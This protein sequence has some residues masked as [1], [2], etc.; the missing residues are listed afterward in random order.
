MGTPTAKSFIDGRAATDKMIYKRALT[1]LYGLSAD[2]MSI[3]W[4]TIQ[5]TADGVMPDGTIAQNNDDIRLIKGDPLRT[6][7]GVIEYKE[8]TP[9]ENFPLKVSLESIKYDAESFNAAV[10]TS[11]EEYEI[12]N[13]P[14]MDSFV[15]PSVNVLDNLPIDEDDPELIKVDWTNN[16]EEEDQPKTATDEYGDTIRVLT[17][18]NAAG[19]LTGVDGTMFVVW[20]GFKYRLQYERDKD[21]GGRSTMVEPSLNSSGAVDHSKWRSRDGEQVYPPY[22]PTKR[23]AGLTNSIAGRNLEVF[24]KDRGLTYKNIEIVPAADIQ[25][26]PYVDEIIGYFFRNEEDLTWGSSSTDGNTYNTSTVEYKDIIYEAG[27]IIKAVRNSENGRKV[28]LPG[29]LSRWTEYHPHKLDKPSNDATVYKPARTER[30][31]LPYEGVLVRGYVNGKANRDFTDINKIG[32]DNDNLID[33]F[34]ILRGTW[35]QLWPWS[36]IVAHQGGPPA[37]VPDKTNSQGG[38]QY[39]NKVGQDKRS[40]VIDGYHGNSYKIL[41][42]DQMQHIG[43]G[44]KRQDFGDENL[45]AFIA[46]FDD[47]L[48]YRNAWKVNWSREQGQPGHESWPSRFNGGEGKDPTDFKYAEGSTNNVDGTAPNEQYTSNGRFTWPYDTPGRISLKS[49]FTTWR[50][51]KGK[52]GGMVR[53]RIYDASG[54]YKGVGK[55][56]N[57]S[58]RGGRQRNEYININNITMERGDTIRMFAKSNS[59]KRKLHMH[60]MQ[61]D[62]HKIELTNL[63]DTVEIG[64]EKLLI[65]GNDNQEMG[66]VTTS[67]WVGKDAWDAY[68]QE[69][70][71]YN[72]KHLEKYNQLFDA[73]LVSRSIKKT[74]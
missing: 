29:Q 6:P 28:Y 69:G 58:D 21:G 39:N 18:I 48:P 71:Y 73:N 2:Q 23:I 10:D 67:P 20:K 25:S 64:Y 24:L 1:K 49:R 53:V 26:F 36:H 33:Y 14:S 55:T 8:E 31:A 70:D 3:F 52:R 32:Q 12:A 27:D 34:M 66:M 5:N 40:D 56:N 17:Q 63:R 11:F 60:S 13:I 37:K 74:V 50:T 9:D 46:S 4:P 65:F 30:S 22:T 42:W 57:F 43:N 38:W 44:L 19:D 51:T 62:V 47:Q 68:I 61:M 45:D 16:P 72:Q 41:D 15:T 35:R 54:K 7:T 59:S